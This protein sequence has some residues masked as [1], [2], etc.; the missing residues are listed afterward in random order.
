MAYLNTVGLIGN[1]GADPNVRDTS[2]GKFA[3]FN[4]ATTERFRDRDGNQ[5][6]Q[7]QW[8][9]ITASGSQ[10][11]V[12]EKYI[13][14]GAQVYVGGKLT[15]RTWKDKDGNDHNSTE[16][17]MHTVQMLDKRVKAEPVTARDD[18]DMPEWMR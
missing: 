13:K 17:R 8:H 10:A 3:T 9:T 1:V 11:E 2:A 5:K 4:L 15:Y 7:T 16:I 14:R 12:V 18:E 6:E